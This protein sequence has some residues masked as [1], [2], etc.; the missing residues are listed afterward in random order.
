MSQGSAVSGLVCPKCQGVMRSYERSGVTVDQ[1]S[2]CRGI[3]LDRG[4]LERLIEAEGA[5]VGGASESGRRVD[6]H[7]SAQRGDD[8]A[9]KRKKRSFLEGLVRG[10]RLS[11]RRGAHGQPVAGEP[12]LRHHRRL[13][14]CARVGRTRSRV[15]CPTVTRERPARAE[16]SARS[17]HAANVPTRSTYRNG[18]NDR[19]S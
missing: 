8:G 13:A 7:G 10:R 18:P 14:V 11:A 19:L 5:Y 17:R 6:E 16:L 12:A 9:P 1:C 2:E 15:D 4:E 3:F